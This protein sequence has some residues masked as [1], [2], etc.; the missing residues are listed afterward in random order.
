MKRNGILL[1]FFI[2]IGIFAG[3]AQSAQTS[4]Q[5]V[6]YKIIASADG[7]YGY[8]ILTDGALLL[9]QTSIPCTPGKRGFINRPDAEK[10]AKLVVEKIKKGELP[11][12]VTRED[13]AK[14]K[15]G[16]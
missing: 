14:L 3:Q 12:T 4:P 2:L 8:D 1:V 15:I 9:H 13:L 7:T 16:Q 11:P 6:S 10:V 5:K